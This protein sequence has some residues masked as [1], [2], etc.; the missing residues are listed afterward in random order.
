MVNPITAET[1]GM[2]SRP[3]SLS[4]ARAADSL[5]AK[6]MKAKPFARLVSLSLDTNTLMTLPNL[7]NISRSSSSSADSLSYRSC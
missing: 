7:E 1:L 2:Y 6:L 5:S 4:S 3:S